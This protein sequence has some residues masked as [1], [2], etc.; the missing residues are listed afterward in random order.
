MESQSQPVL[1]ADISILICLYNILSAR[2]Y[3]LTINQFY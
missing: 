2:E 3:A 1:F